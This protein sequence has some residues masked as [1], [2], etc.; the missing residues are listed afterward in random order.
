M[1]SMKII[2]LQAEAFKRLRAVQIAP[3]SNIVEITG[4]NGEGKSSTLDAIWAAL[5]GK[6]ASPDKPIHTGKDRAEVRLVL[7]DDGQPQ[8]KVTR[9]WR[10]REDGSYA[11][12]LIV[13][14][15]DGA[16]F[17]KPQNMLD[18]LVGALCFDIEAF[19]RMSDA[20]QIK[21]LQAFVPGVDFADI[22]AKNRKDFEERTEV[23]R[24]IRN[25]EGALES[26]PKP[27]VADVPDI[28]IRSIEAQLDAAIKHN[29]DAAQLNAARRASAR[30]I[31]DIA[32][33]IARLKAEA[34]SLRVNHSPEEVLLLDTSA[35]IDTIQTYRQ[36]SEARANAK[37]YE[38]ASTKLAKFKA[39]HLALTDS[40]A[41]RKKAMADAVLAAKMPIDGLGFGEGHV[42]LN[43]EPIAQAS[44]AQKI[45]ASVAIAAAMNPRLRVARVTDGSLLDRKS[46][47]AL[48]DYAAE[49]DLQIW[50]ETVTQHGK[51]AILIEDGGVAA[52][53]A[54]EEIL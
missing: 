31:D 10:L 53:D 4:D 16:R 42:T 49:H 37:R 35:L 5:G 46:W 27:D 13:E 44:H 54:A 52:P 48:E 38:E 51:A 18:R 45:R 19:L 1:S 9:N 26:M 15:A 39:R 43:G 8:V 3:T 14:S 29:E 23:G 47:A 11:T 12:D 2:E 21:A 17:P 20:E 40:I 28:D 36:T 32:N 34:E 25:L 50:V 24:D 7:G 30:R 6:D 41:A 22:E 33:E